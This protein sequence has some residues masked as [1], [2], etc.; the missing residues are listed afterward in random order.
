MSNCLVCV[1]A[2]ALCFQFEAEAEAPCEGIW[3]RVWCHIQQAWVWVCCSVSAVVSTI[4][5]WFDLSSWMGAGERE[6]TPPSA[7]DLMV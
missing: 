2:R 3:S 4:S 5:S 6:Q 7:G 1:D